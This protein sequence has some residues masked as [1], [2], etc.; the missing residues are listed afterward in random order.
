VYQSESVDFCQAVPEAVRR[1]RIYNIPN[2]ETIR[3]NV[4]SPWTR[5]RV[6]VTGLAN[7]PNLIGL[8]LKKRM[9]LLSWG[10]TFYQPKVID[11]MA[12]DLQQARS[13]VYFAH[14][15]LPHTPWVYKGDCQL[16][17]SSESWE[18]FIGPG[19]KRN[20]V[21]QRAVRYLRYL[22]QIS[23]ALKEMDRLFDQMRKLGLYDEATIVV[24]G[25]HGSRISL[26]SPSY[27][28]RDNLTPEDYRDV[29]SVLFAIKQ[30]GGGYR[31]HPETVPLNVLMQ[32][33]AK[34]ISRY[35]KSEEES[36]NVPED[37]PF[38][39]LTDTFPLLRHEINIF[40]QP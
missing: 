40:E 35:K 15:L 11:E 39:Y 30:P 4:L 2:L 3:D 28:N 22:P 27:L 12:N 33:T 10:V 32:R 19:L 1:C 31:E 18:R 24:H 5:F 16:D 13:G 26:H 38:I 37:L 29:Y 23:C 7:G 17:Y 21:D 8:F 36:R 20:S 6:L 9:W 25:D 34:I 14:L